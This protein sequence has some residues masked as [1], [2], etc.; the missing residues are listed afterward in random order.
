MHNQSPDIKRLITVVLFTL[1]LVGAYLLVALISIYLLPAN[2]S[3]WVN[4]IL[5]AIILFVS[6]V[7]FVTLAERLGLT[8]TSYTESAFEKVVERLGLTMIQPEQPYLEIEDEVEKEIIG[9][10]FKH[11]LKQQGHWRGWVEK[12]EI[13]LFNRQIK[14]SRR[15]VQMTMVSMQS[16]TVSPSFIVSTHPFDTYYL[17]RAYRRQAQ[18]LFETGHKDLEI[19]S[20]NWET[21]QALLNKNDRAKLN[22][23]LDR[24]APFF[25]FKWDDRIMFGKSLQIN[26]K[27]NRTE[28]NHIQ[29]YPAEIEDIIGAGASV[30]ALFEDASGDS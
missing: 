20:N 29:D 14:A 19:R 5:F 26:R 4:L 3:Q 24:H 7:M 16:K 6:I 22:E 17:K 28:L 21:V 23:I 27:G 30:M 10:L 25:I 8:F 1:M 9:Q 12:R 2:T 11:N 15:P 18:P 13:E